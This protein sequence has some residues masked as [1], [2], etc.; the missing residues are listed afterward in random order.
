M[1]ETVEFGID[2]RI[3][4]NPLAHWTAADIA[5]YFTRYDLPPHPLRAAGYH[6]IGCAPCTRVVR[7]GE[8]PRAGRWDGLDKTE[9][10]I[11][12]APAFSERASA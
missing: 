11:H 8:D 7:P 1:L 6:S 9:C 2:W 3:K 4:V 12:R 5:A 10:G